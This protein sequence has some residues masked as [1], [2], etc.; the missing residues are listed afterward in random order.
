MGRREQEAR[1]AARRE[2]ADVEGEHFGERAVEDRREFVS[3]DEAR[4]LVEREGE[5][6]AR[7]LAVGQFI[8]RAQEQSRFGQAAGREQIESMVELARKG[9]D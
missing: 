5:A 4:L 7:P 8:R 3:E 2:L 9:V 6:E 1:A